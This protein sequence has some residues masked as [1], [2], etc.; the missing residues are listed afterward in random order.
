MS[1]DPEI[2]TEVVVEEDILVPSI[3][4]CSFPPLNQTDAESITN[5]VKAYKS[6]L[7]LQDSCWAYFPNVSVYNRPK[8]SS[9][10]LEE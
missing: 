1:I 3:W 6:A 7:S 5:H 8:R 9:Q 10:N 4:G 2:P